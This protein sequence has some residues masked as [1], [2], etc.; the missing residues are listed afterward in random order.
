MVYEVGCN[1]HSMV[2]HVGRARSIRRV[3]EVFRGVGVPVPGQ[4]QEGLIKL[5]T[6][7]MSES[8][9]S[10]FWVKEKRRNV[11]SRHIVASIETL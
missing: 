9:S 7:N 4:C 10:N 3:V 5:S 2:L 6:T 1:G 11:E 8:L